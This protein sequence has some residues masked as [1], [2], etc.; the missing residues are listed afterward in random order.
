MQHKGE[1]KTSFMN[2]FITQI[3]KV[4]ALCNLYLINQKGFREAD[5]KSNVLQRIH[6]GWRGDKNV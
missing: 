1:N 3:D 2:E 4:S 5:L 6:A